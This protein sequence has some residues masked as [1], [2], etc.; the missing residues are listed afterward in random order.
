M[1]LTDEIGSVLWS[2][3][4][5]P[6]FA[7]YFRG[8]VAGRVGSTSAIVLDSS[9]GERDHAGVSMGLSN[10]LDRAF[11][12]ELRNSSSM[13]ITTGAT[14]RAE[15]VHFPANGKLGVLSRQSEIRVPRVSA[16][17]QLFPV[18]WRPVGG[19][20]PES[21]AGAKPFR[22]IDAGG[23][24][25]NVGD[26]LDLGILSQ[27]QHLHFEAG[28]ETLASLWKSGLIARLWVTHPSEVRC[29]SICQDAQ[30]TEC[31]M[32]G[33]LG[34]SLLQPAVTAASL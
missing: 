10:A 28:L 8:L 27:E 7:S 34:L 14:I 32:L 17:G 4:A 9:G 3:S 16:N 23:Q 29:D 20:Q 11:L 5:K 1:L 6:E 2:A 31:V 22:A 33:S 18:L 30:V 15:G 26:P 13:V 25:L 19:Q 12:V 24:P 21:A